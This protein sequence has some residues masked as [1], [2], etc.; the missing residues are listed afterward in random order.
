[1]HNKLFIVG[2]TV[3]SWGEVN[4]LRAYNPIKTNCRDGAVFSHF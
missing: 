2:N 3:S 4:S 1:M